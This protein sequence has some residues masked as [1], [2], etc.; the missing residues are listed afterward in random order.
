MA[1]FNAV[2]SDVLGVQARIAQ[3][4]FSNTT[5][6]GGL[7]V[8]SRQYNVLRTTPWYVGPRRNRLQGVMFQGG[9][10]DRRQGLWRTG[11]HRAFSKDWV[12][13][14]WLVVCRRGRR[15]GYTAAAL[16]QDPASPR[17]HHRI[18]SM[19][20]LRSVRCHATRQLCQ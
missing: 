16:I 3:P 7:P 10:V 9:D 14:R 17:T 18:Y 6:Q 13:S 20:P 19:Q 1:L 12:S 4:G 15:S 11:Y 5:V 8:A 2:L